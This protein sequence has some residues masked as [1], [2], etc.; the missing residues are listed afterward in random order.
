MR[1]LV[2]TTALCGLVLSACGTSSTP[3][4][5]QTPSESVPASEQDLQSKPE[6]TVDTSAFAPPDLVIEDLVVGTGEVA[7]PGSV[8]SVHYV[9][10]SLST[11]MEFD[12]SWDRGEPFE[13]ELGARQVIEGWDLG[14]EGMMVGGRRKLT[15]PSSLAYGENGAGGVI[16]PGETLIFVVDLLAVEPAP[17]PLDLGLTKPEFDVDTSAEPPT[18]LVIEDLVEGEGDEA[19]AGAEITVHYVGKSLSTGEQF[20][21]SWDRGQYFTFVLGQGRVIQGWDQ[22]FEGMKVGGRRMLTIPSELGYGEQGSPPNI[23]PGETL[24]FVVDLLAVG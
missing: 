17:E 22:G 4:G 1:R 19:V 2:A 8:V 13:F 9:G 11:G 3:L 23:A 7:V 24:I 20:D 18:E 14:V 5:S 15:I 6:F 16:A 12:A 21:A 10:K